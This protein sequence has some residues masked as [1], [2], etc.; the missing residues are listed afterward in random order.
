[1]FT[2][3]SPVPDPERIATFLGL[4]VCRRKA[5]AGGMSSPDRS[6]RRLSLVG[7]AEPTG[8]DMRRDILVGSTRAADLAAILGNARRNGRGCL[9]TC[10]A[11]PDRTPSLSIMDGGRV[12][13]VAKCFAGCDSREVLAELRRLGLLD[14]C[15]DH[16]GDHRGDHRPYR[17]IQRA[18]APCTGSGGTIDR[19]LL[20]CLPIQGTLA[21][22]YLAS[23]RLDLPVSGDVLRCLPPS[24]RYIWPT[25]V[26]VITDFVTGQT[27]NL[28]FTYLAID[29]SGKAPLPK[30]EQRR[31]SWQGIA[32]R[33]ASSG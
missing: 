19:V 13:M 25:M 14:D 2:S 12:P 29:G 26:S 27:I 22:A 33:V 28:Q 16:R 9:C 32:S 23:R 7:R 6:N 10:P 20:R 5:K 4:P 1:M 18:G 11:H 31:F 17:T 30:H 3:I 24:A 8:D 21:E 15:A